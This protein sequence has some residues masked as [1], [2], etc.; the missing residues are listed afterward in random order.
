[1]FDLVT[2]FY[3]LGGTFCSGTGCSFP[4]CFR[5]LSSKHVKCGCITGLVGYVCRMIVRYSVC[6]GQVQREKK[7]DIIYSGYHG[8]SFP[9]LSYS[10]LILDSL[11]LLHL[12]LC[13]CVHFTQLNRRLCSC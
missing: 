1:M 10:C 13:Y 2:I 3:V 6:N 9:L 12:Y 4:L 11:S 8:Y 7:I 5:L